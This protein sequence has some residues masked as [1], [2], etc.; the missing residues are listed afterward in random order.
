MLLALP[1]VLS[2]SELKAVRTE[3]QRARFQD[4]KLSAGMFARRVK[5]NEELETGSV[6][7]DRLNNMVMGRLVQHPVY[8]AGAMPLRVAAPYYA[9]YG[10]GMGYGEH[11]DDPIMQGDL[12]YRSDIAITIFLTDVTDYDGGELE[13]RTAFGMNQVKLPAGDAVMY[14]ASSRHRVAPVTRGERLVAVTWV[15]S[16]VRDSAQRELLYELNLAREKMLR[17]QPDA[18]ETARINHA[19]VNLVRMWA[20]L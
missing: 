1:Q 11:T 16:A 20:D 6:D 18:E 12:P 19:Y 14:P 9:R 3:L 10:V 5:E 2:A 8:R 15:Q 17:E 4:G 7:I 13:I